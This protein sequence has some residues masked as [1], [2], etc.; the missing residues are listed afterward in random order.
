VFSQ[1]HHLSTDQLR[2]DLGDYGISGNLGGQNP[3]RVGLNEKGYG[4]H[5]EADVCR[6]VDRF[7][8]RSMKRRGRI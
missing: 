3:D 6:I 7:S 8:D 4:R 2:Q 5:T 1:I